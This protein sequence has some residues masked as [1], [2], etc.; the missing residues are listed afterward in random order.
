MCVSAVSAS[1]LSP[2]SAAVASAAAAAAAAGCYA[3]E[4]VGGVCFSGEIPCNRPIKH[5]ASRNG[6]RLAVD[7]ATVRQPPPQQRRVLLCRTRPSLEG[8][9][10]KSRSRNM[11]ISHVYAAYLRT[12]SAVN[13]ET[14]L[15]IKTTSSK[16]DSILPIGLISDCSCIPIIKKSFLFH[17][18]DSSVSI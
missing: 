4:D 10:R 6:L 17:L 7:A 18:N 3:K 16:N 9:F 11:R 15:S 8:R 2:T 12:A 13:F 14:F 1:S 5:L